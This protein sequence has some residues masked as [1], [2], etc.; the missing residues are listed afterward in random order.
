VCANAAAEV[1][2]ALDTVVDVRDLDRG[3]VLGNVGGDRRRRDEGGADR[4]QQN[5]KQVT[6]VKAL[7]LPRHQ[8]LVPNI[9][10]L[11]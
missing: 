10:G 4:H 7:D 5:C 3:I 2:R 9:A 11:P 1:E 8:S 6:H